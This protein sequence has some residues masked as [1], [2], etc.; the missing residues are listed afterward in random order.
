[1]A[2]F[3]PTSYDRR[4]AAR[5]GRRAGGWRDRGRLVRHRAGLGRGRLGAA[6]H[7]VADAAELGD[8]P[9]GHVGRER[10]AVPAVLVLDLGEALALDRLGQD[11][12]RPAARGVPGERHRLVDGGEVVPV[13]RQHPRAERLHPPRVLRQVPADVGLAALAEPVDVG[14]RDQVR[15]PVVGGLVERLPDRALG[16]LAVPAQHPDPVREPVQVPARQRD[17]DAVGQPLAERAG[18]DVDPRQDRRGVALQP[19][20]E[21]PVAGHQLVLR[22]D[23]GR[24]EHRVQQRRGVAL[25]ED[26]VVVD[27]QPRLIPVVAQVPGHQHRQQVRGRHARRRMPGPGAGRGPNRVDP[28][29]RGQTRNRVEADHGGRMRRSHV[30]SPLIRV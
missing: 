14:D 16:Q 1:M 10:L 5:R 12:R 15:Q 30:L 11:H 27:R 7:Q 8:G 26:Q 6:Q 17:P 3:A 13:D 20:A 25:G 4:R 28:Q 9:V 21:A 19:L 2:T 18:G 22:H 29:L 24:L 23:P